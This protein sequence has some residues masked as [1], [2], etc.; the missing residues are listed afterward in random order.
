MTWSRPENCEQLKKLHRAWEAASTKAWKENSP[1]NRCA[2]RGAQAALS[3]A[4][5]RIVAEFSHEQG[6]Q[7]AR[8]IFSTAQL[9]QGRPGRNFPGDYAGYDGRAID[10]PDFFR[11]PTRPFRPAGI[12]VHVY[13][14]DF[15]ICHAYAQEWG[16]L[17]EPLPWS[18]YYPDGTNAGVFRHIANNIIDITDRFHRPALGGDAA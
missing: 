1:E 17:F 6:W 2:L 11:L 5:R 7:I 12:V 13:L 14:P 9:A 18:W 4:Q 16:I 10:H 3:D 8:H 15:E